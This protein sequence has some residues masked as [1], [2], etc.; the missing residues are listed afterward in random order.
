MR[1]IILGILLGGLVSAAIIWHYSNKHKHVE[2]VKD[3]LRNAAMHAE[4]AIRDKLN[5]AN[6]SPDDIKDELART[7]KIVRE[8]AESA[9]AAVADAATDAR[10]TSTIK[11]RLVADSGTSALSISVSTKDGIVNLSGTAPSVGEIQKAFKT[12]MNTDGVHK[13]VSTIQVKK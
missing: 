9:G 3:Y 2:L 1:N 10:I 5:S 4:E 8:K 13:V 6:L 12:A 11:A 7:G